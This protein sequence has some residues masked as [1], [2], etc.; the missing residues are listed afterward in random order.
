[1]ENLRIIEL[2]LLLVE[3]YYPVL[4]K[5]LRKIL[6]N[7]LF[8][9]AQYERPDHL[10]KSGHSLLIL[11]FYNRCLKFV[12]KY[13]ITIQKSRH[14]VIKYAPQLTKS[15]LNRSSR[16]CELSLASYKLYSLCCRCG[17]VFDVLCLIYYLIFKNL[18]IV[19]IDI[20]L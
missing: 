7:I 19:K 12:L 10:L 2:L 4:L 3:L 6:K 5:L 20:P 8:K 11:I 13:I 16:Q 9:A 17:L 14:K 15:V 18:S 1:M